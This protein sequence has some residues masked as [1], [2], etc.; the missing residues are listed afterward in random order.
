M[1]LSA[2]GVYVEEL[3]SGVRT[4]AGVA[5][6]VT[7][8][9]GRCRRGDAEPDARPTVVS[10]WGDFV[11]ACGDVWADSELPTAVQQYFLAGGASALIVRVVHDDATS[12]SFDLGDGLTLEATSPGTW[13]NDLVVKV[14]HPNADLGLGD[15]LVFH[16][17]VGRGLGDD[18][19][20]FEEHRQLSVDP[21]SAR[22][23]RRVLRARSPSLHV[24][25]DSAVRPAAADATR[26]DGGDGSAPS[27]SEMEAAFDRLRFADTV[28]LVCVPPYA[29][30]G[31]SPALSVYEAALVV[32]EELRAMVLV[33]P[34]DS[35][36]DVA[37]AA[38]MTGITS[39]QSPNVIMT[40]PAVRASD[41]VRDGLERTFAPS[42]FFAGLVAKTD[43]TRGVWVSPAGLDGQLRGVSNLEQPLTEA[44]IG[45]L[46]Q[47][48]VNALVRRGV[49]GPVVWGSRTSFGADTRG[50]E[51]KFVAVRR[52]ALYIEE[53]LRR[54]LQWAVFEPNDS[55]LHA[56]IR[57]AVGGFMQQLF[58][59][60]AFAG[61][62]VREA[63]DVKC[64]AETTTPED[65]AR[66]VVNIVVR[67]APLKPAE[68]V[69]LTFQQMAGQA[70]S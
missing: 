44:E 19:V 42:S 17:L 62:Q 51:W 28:N 8:F 61:S 24:A 18:F 15:P 48:G 56:E 40:Y 46:N 68:F 69:V 63:Y 38:L 70:G 4:I 30:D 39:L 29:A 2:P 47:R 37:T 34:P 5:T 66:G 55:P 49:A 41:P 53:S 59:Q 10:S 14:E 21:N 9:V 64:D 65:V 27:D 26:T 67:F 43:A 12:A 35:W 54:G 58:R 32:A 60:G 25:T 13:A 3:P 23:V 7:A 31:G 6:S 36:G 52:L 20:A 33:D 45:Q 1:A 22:N 11:R 57:G 50:S 16:L